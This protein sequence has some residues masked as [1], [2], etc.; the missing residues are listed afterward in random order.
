MSTKQTWDDVA[1]AMKYEMVECEWKLFQEHYLPFIPSKEAIDDCAC[2]LERSGV[3]KGGDT[4]P[5][6]WRDFPG[7]AATTSTSRH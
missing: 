4:N 5:F 2:Y 6:P 3:L 7:L 1:D